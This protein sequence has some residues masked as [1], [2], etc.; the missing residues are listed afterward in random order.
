MPSN[1]ST[2]DLTQG[3]VGR[4]IMNLAVPGML[5]NLMTFST[6]LVDMMWVGRISPEAIAAITTH[7]YIWF[8]FSILNQMIGQGSV[9]LI[10]RSYG[11]GDRRRSAEVLGETFFFKLVVAF[12][13]MGIGLLTMAPAYRLFGITDETV[14]RY[15]MQYSG[16]MFLATPLLFSTFTL[17]T[18]FRAVGAATQLFW[19]S[20]MTMMINL[21]LDPFLIF[22]R[23]DFT[24]P[25]VN[26]H[27]QS[28]GIGLEVAG[29]A[30]ASVL[31]FAITFVTTLF[32]FLTGRTFIKLSVRDLFSP[33]M[34]TARK[35]L[36]IGLPPAAGNSLEHFSNVL[37]GSAVNTYGTTV[38]AAQGVNNMLQRLIQFSIMGFSW[39]TITMV[40]QNLGA[41]EVQ[42]AEKSVN[43]SAAI[44][45]GVLFLVAVLFYFAAPG[46]AA[47]FMPVRD[48]ASRETV[49]WIIR[50]LRVNCFLYLPLGLNRVYRAVFEGS[51]DTRP[52]FWS[53]A[54]TTWGLQIPLI[55]TGVYIMRIGEPYFIWWIMVAGNA[56]A[57][58]ILYVMFR[59][60]AWKHH[61]V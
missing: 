27:F 20:A 31:A 49:E 2:Q 9:T 36:K 21:V 46:I 4:H 16:I 17:K 19:V 39:S 26:Y 55:M 14:F 8:L 61:T 30:Y 60:G 43:R 1:P 37:I 54:A 47:L 38:Y 59:R 22:E 12:I 29:A 24:V 3:S 41:S 15:G 45:A 50:I 58:V 52:V 7:Q 44:I 23:I 11:S 5:T 33:S 13:V 10:A 40:G 25:I 48:D 28:A 34:D 57:A 6:T 32:L 51:G 53:S 42:R 56:A 18:G 35:I